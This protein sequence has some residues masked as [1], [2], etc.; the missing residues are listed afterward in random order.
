MSKQA[1][2]RALL[3]EKVA[4]ISPSNPKKKITLQKNFDFQNRHM[5]INDGKFVLKEA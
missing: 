1:K 2:T 5:S 4:K 3:L